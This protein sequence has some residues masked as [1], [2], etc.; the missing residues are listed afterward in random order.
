MCSMKPAFFATPEKMR[1]LFEEQHGKLEELWVGFYKRDS[2]RP[3]VTWPQSVDVALCYGWID[4]V[5]RS[6]DG[7]SYMIRFTPR[8]AQSTWSAI[9]IRRVGELKKSGLMRPAGLKA[10]ERRSEKKSQIYSYEQRAQAK[11]DGISEK[12]F[13]SKRAAWD[14]FQ[15]QPPWYRRTSTYWVMTAKKEETRQR[16]L[17]KLIDDSAHGR[18]LDQLTRKK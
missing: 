1:A 3:S 5:R 14:F 8:K 17:A 13:K 12:K 6:I 9:N 11:F 15:A 2:G 16:R 18:T 4:G 7:V 10:F